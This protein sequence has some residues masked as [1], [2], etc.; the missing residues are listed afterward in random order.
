M[1]DESRR[2]W[3][4]GVILAPA[5]IAAIAVAVEPFWDKLVDAI[6]SPPAPVNAAR[7]ISEGEAYAMTL[8]GRW[9]PVE[10]SA[11]DYALTLTSDETLIRFYLKGAQIEQYH[12]RDV[13]ADKLLVEQQAS[14]FRFWKSGANLN[15]AGPE[16]LREFRPC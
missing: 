14:T 5:V 16:G 11:C 15:I 8:Q 7:E 13:V 12:I 3:F 10:M 9:R 2:R 6:W 4:I 1:S